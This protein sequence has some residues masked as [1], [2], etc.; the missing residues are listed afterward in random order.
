MEIK[1]F[2]DLEVWNKAKD[3]VLK[4]YKMTVNFP[5]EETYSITSQM[6]RAALSVPANIAEGFG[7]YHYLNKA[8]FYLNS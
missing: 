2:E 4:I 5:K 7:R 1:S 3:L 6:K 8:K